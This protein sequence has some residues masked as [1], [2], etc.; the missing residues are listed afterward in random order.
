MLTPN[1]ARS[2]SISYSSTMFIDLRIEYRKR[3]DNGK[4]ITFDKKI[5]II[6]L[7]KFQ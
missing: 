2:R 5:T 3:L 6:S 1:D 4:I 7:G